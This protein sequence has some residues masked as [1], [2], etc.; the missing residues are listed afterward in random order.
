LFA[1]FV[2]LLFISLLTP[3]LV[4]VV[5]LVCVGPSLWTRVHNEVRPTP[6]LD[7]QKKVFCGRFPFG[8]SPGMPGPKENQKLRCGRAL[9]YGLPL[10]SVRAEDSS[11]RGPN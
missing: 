8:V 5:V 1:L 7:H 9:R 6:Q 3:K 2:F 10:P 4:W 11:P